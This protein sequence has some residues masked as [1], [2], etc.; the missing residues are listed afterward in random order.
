MFNTFK[1][2]I[3]MKK[4]LAIVLVLVMVIGLAACGNGGNTTPA[5]NGNE[6]KSE[7]AGTYKIKVWCPDAAVELTKKQIDDFNKTNTLGIVIEPTV[8]A[9]GEGTAADSMVQDVEAGGDLFFFAQDQLARL[10]NAAAVSQL[11][12]AA[13]EKVKA[14]NDGDSLIAI[15]AGDAYYAYPLTSDNGYFMYY[16]KSV[17][18][19]EDAKSLEKIVAACEAAGKNFVMNLNNSGWY[20]PAFFFGTGCVSEWT[21]DAD[22][23]FTAVNDDFNSDKG[24]AAAKAMNFLENSKCHVQDSNVSAFSS[25][26]AA[27]VSG[28]WDYNTAKGILK[29]NLGIAKLPTFTVDGQTYQMGS[30]KGCKLLGVKPQSD[31]KKAAA[32]NQLAQFLTSEEV[33]LERC[34]ELAWGPANKNA[35]NSDLVKNSP[36]LIAVYDQAQYAH[37]QGNISGAWWGLANALADNIKNAKNDDELKA[38]LA[39]YDTEVHSLV[40]LDGFI[41]VGAWNGWDNADSKLK[42]EEAGGVYTITIDVPQSDYMGG[43]IVS[44]GNWDTDKGLAQVKEGKDLLSE[45]GGNDNNMVFLKPGNYTVTFNESTGEINVKAN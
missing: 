33:Q 40:G 44:A 35:Q 24:L 2:E 29:D 25:G 22:G 7:I 18:S 5:N 21:I 12:K 32:I 41:F 9:V 19:D 38:A 4:V 15:S 10:I 11:G 6:A 43:R 1:E 26:A 3:F 8:E 16:D 39:T 34:K 45:D 14:E 17:I 20:T 42:M 28:T 13:A 31:A 37:M 27:V 30:F 23:K 36:Q